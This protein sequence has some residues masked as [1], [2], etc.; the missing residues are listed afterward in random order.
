ME[1]ATPFLK[2]QRRS[3]RPP[4]LLEALCIFFHLFFPL[5][6]KLVTVRNGGIVCCRCCEHCS[7]HFFEFIGVD[8]IVDASGAVWLIECN[9]PPCTTTATGLQ[10]AE[11]LHAQVARDILALIVV[12]AVHHRA[13]DSNSAN[14]ADEHQQQKQ[15]KVEK[16]D[17]ENQ[18][19]NGN[20]QEKV[21]G[22]GAAAALLERRD[23]NQGFVQCREGR[24]DFVPSPPLKLALNAFSWSKLVRSQ[25]ANSVR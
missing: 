21:A 25:K 18:N 14:R 8:W 24:E 5:L 4:F 22:G 7:A 13:V 9:R 23:G 2:F 6:L 20:L 10:E 19:Q 11:D 16:I 17:S 3:E 12:P 1:A 15:E